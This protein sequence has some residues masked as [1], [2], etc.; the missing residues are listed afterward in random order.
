MRRST[1]SVP[2]AARRDHV[3]R[4]KIVLQHVAPTVWRTIQVPATDNFWDLHVAI[5]D[6]MGWLDYH[7]HL[8]EV[9]DDTGKTVRVGIPDDDPY[10]GD[11]PIEPG[12]DVPI[13]MYF[14]R[15]G[16]EARYVS[17]FGDGWRHRVILEAIEPRRRRQRH[18][19]CLAGDR[20]CP[21]EDSGGPPGYAQKLAIARNLRH[22]EHE[23][24]VQWLG[25][26]FDPERCDPARVKFDDPRRR[27]QLAFGPE[28]ARLERARTPRSGRRAARPGGARRRDQSVPPPV[29][30]SHANI[31]RLLGT[32]GAITIGRVGPIDCAATA[33]DGSRQIAALVRLPGES[34]EDLL[35]RLDAAIASVWE[36]DVVIDEIN[37]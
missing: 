36:D 22:P 19:V 31:D 1:G 27:W 37:G 30:T 11:E 21:P 7:L 15:P 4:F 10:E 20:A 29:A 6:A 26:R 9:R 16:S 8:F 25:A 5:Q 14:P 32:E 34:L 13:A 35:T 23:D 28:P 33:F 18:P 24:I 2:V 3:C 17:D 12:W